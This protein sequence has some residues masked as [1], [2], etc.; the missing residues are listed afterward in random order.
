MEDT[1]PISYV[2]VA[3]HP[4]LPRLVTATT[5]PTPLAFLPRHHGEFPLPC[6]V[7]AVVVTPWMPSRSPNLGEPKAEPLGSTPHCTHWNT[8][9]S[10]GTAFLSPWRS[11]TLA[12]LHRAALACRG[13]SH[14]WRGPVSASLSR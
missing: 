8:Y 12:P 11:G 1:A 7:L 5:R 14:P 4:A 6:P 9:T 13:Q 2:D 3:A 10:Q